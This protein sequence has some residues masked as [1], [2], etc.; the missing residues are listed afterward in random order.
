MVRPVTDDDIGLKVLREAPA[1]AGQIIDIVTIHSIGDHPDDSW[2]KN[3]STAESAARV[4]WLTK[5]DM[6]LA[7]APNAR[8]IQYG[9]KS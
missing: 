6:L 7:V 9:Y 3:V 4:N 5:E 2:C 1:E 8:I